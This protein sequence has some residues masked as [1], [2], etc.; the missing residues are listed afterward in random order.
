MEPEEL[1][2]DGEL[3][4]RRMRDDPDD[5]NL[6]VRWR[7]Q[8]HVAE[9]WSTDEDPS[10]TT[11]DRVVE[12]YGPRAEDGAWAIGCI[13][14]TGD[15]AVGYIQFY[16]W[17]EVAD[18][19][20]EVGIPHVDGS[21]GLDVF[22]G[23]PDVVDHGIGSRAVALVARYLFDDR[24]ATAV[25]LL[26]SIDN[27]RAQRAYERAG[28]RKVRRTLDTDVVNGQRVASWL[29]VLDRPLG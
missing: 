23:E 2:R 27:V 16:P 25:A 24:G 20:R 7:N 17:S 19:A 28:F 13:I 11:F 10:P 12:G 1:A 6:V 4:I 3:S 26:T 22:I 21:F 9:W 29:M 5:Y 15:R 14:T 8:P 18:E